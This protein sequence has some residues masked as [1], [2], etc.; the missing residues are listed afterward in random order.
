MRARS[1]RWPRR[2]TG[3]RVGGARALALEAA[4]LASILAAAAALRLA[5]LD[6]DQ[7]RHLHPDER[8]LSL[9]LTELRPAPDLW[10]YFDPARSPLNPFNHGIDFFVYGTFPLFLVEGLARALGREGYDAAYLVGRALSALFDVGTV[11]AVWLIGRELLGRWPALLAA[12]LLALAVHSI[13]IA[14]FFAVDTFA[15]FFSTLALWSLVRFQRTGGPRAWALAGVSVGLA[16]ASKSSAGLLLVLAVGWWI[17]EGLRT[18]VY[19]ERGWGG[20]RWAWLAHLGAFLALAALT[21]RLFQPYAFASASPLDWRLSREFAGALAQQQAIQ[22][23]AFDWPPGVQWAGTAP[24]LYPLE[25]IV[26]WGAGPGF[27]LAALAGLALAAAVAWRE[28]RHPLALPLAWGALGFAVPGAFVLKTMRYFHPVYPVLALV[29]AWMFAWLWARRRRPVLGVRGVGAL[30]TAAALAGVLT[31]ALLWTLAF[32]QIYGRDHAR[33]EASRFIYQHV[34]A[35]AAIAVEHWDDALPLP[36]PGFD[37]GRYT[38]RELR[39]FERD[40]EAKRAHLLEVL[41]ASGVVVLSSDR[42]AAAIPR[43]P[44]RYPLTRAYYAALQDGSLGFDLLAR[45]TS[46]PSLGAWVIDDRQAEEAFTVYD[47]PTVSIY[48]RRAGATAADVQRRLGPVD[49][50][51]AVDVLPRDAVV[52]RTDQTPEEAARTAAEAGWPSQFEQRPLRG[53][54]AALAWFAALWL[55]GMLT[56]PLLWP[57]LRRLPDRG[58]AAARVLGPAVVAFPAWWLASLGLVRFDAPLVLGCAAVLAA[59]AAAALWRR[60]AEVRAPLAAALG[61]IAATEA[62]AAAAFLVMLLLRARNPD[63]WHPVFGGEKPMD[64]AH[65][66]AVMR[67]PGFPPHDPWFAGSRLNYYYGGHVPTAGLAKT[68]GTP[69]ATA[70][71]L[72]IASA[73]GA[74]ATAVFGAAAA[75]WLAAGRRLGGGGCEGK[76]RPSRRRWLAAVGVGLAGV[77]LTLL[78]GNLHSIVQLAALA[79]RAAGA[80]GVGLLAAPGVL[81]G[82]DLAREFDF[83]AATRVLPDTVNEFPWFTFMYGDLHPHLMNLANTA[84]A[85]LG[86]AA[87]LGLGERA[88]RGRRDGRRAWIGVLALQTFVLGLHRVTNPWDYPTSTVVTAAVLAYVLW[89]SRRLG[90][91]AAAAAGIGAA[92]LLPALTQALFWPFHAAYVDFFGGWDPTPATTPAARWLLV[93]GLPAAVL[94]TY[95]AVVLAASLR[96][97]EPGARRG[98]LAALT[99]SGACI[100]AGLLGS[101]FDWSTRALLAGLLGLAAAAAWQARARPARLAPLACLLAGLGLTAI[102]EVVV[103][104][105][106]IGR[107]NTVFKTYLQAWMLLGLGAALALPVLLQSLA[108]VRRRRFAWLRLVWAGGLSLLAAAALAYPLLATP[109]KLSL[110]IQ[111]LPDTLDGEAFMDGGRISDPDGGPIDL[112][113]DWHAIRWLRANVP[114]APVV[115]ETPTTIY[116][117]GGRVAVYTGLPSVIAWDWHAKQQHWGYVHEAE[118]RFDDARELFATPDL[119]RARALLSTYNVGLVYVG[120]LERALYPAASLAKFDRMA[121]LGV[122]AVY[123][124]GRT[125]IYRVHPGG[126]PAVG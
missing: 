77:A 4:A 92:V 16:M 102:P 44:Q 62:L 9:V 121:P 95:A 115:A 82:G 68:L 65:L 8:F 2:L 3:A 90:A 17:F 84:A 113:A 125:V 124:D 20:R 87:L 101:G 123:R 67:S 93:F 5:G 66:N 57:A 110:R 99:V 50:R 24:W 117:W 97:A 88:R 48:V 49:V 111:P 89:R 47:H 118:A 109:H 15:T 55:A 19:A 76:N 108:R 78:A 112:S 105:D 58:Y 61:L 91:R 70:Y 26:R 69:P 54:G 73:F 33:V 60:R 51:G 103:V 28:R 39:V 32:V 116:R 31:A 7:G 53:P 104:R 10:T 98:W 12:A 96:R 107:L 6:W 63:L 38:R 100:A 30:L 46:R 119:Q 43:M 94:A 29:T 83:W 41:G 81:V 72:A 52:R 21:F 64:F 37:P 114:G 120:E 106:D 13:Q 40:S 27:G 126:A 23:G 45:F 18:R 85:L 14:H 25:Q 42:G 75:A 22:S 36:L 80:E 122:R 56:W 59:L 34:P 1:A 86:C 71:N 74:A 79:Q 35:G 11:A